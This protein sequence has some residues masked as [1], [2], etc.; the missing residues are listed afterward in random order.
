MTTTRRRLTRQGRRAQIAKAAAEVLAARESS[1]VSFE[2]IAA[3]AGVS[4]SLVYKH[5]GDRSS[6]LAAAYLHDL[7]RL[8][9]YIDAAIADCTDDGQRLRAVIEA[10]LAFAEENAASSRLIASLGTLRHPAVQAAMQTRIV[11]IAAHFGG[12]PEALLVARGVVGLL[13][14][15]TIYWADNRIASSEDAVDLLFRVLRDGLSQV[16]PE[17][18]YSPAGSVSA[19]PLG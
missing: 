13:E 5:F 11:R 1:D 15:V 8:D 6:L 12:S 9:S 16:A 18:G 17:L 7:D 3:A 19:R 4:R 14:S 10:Y 2:E